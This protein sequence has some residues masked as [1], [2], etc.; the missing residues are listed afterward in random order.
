[1]EWD[2]SNQSMQNVLNI[3]DLIQEIIS[4]VD[5]PKA[6]LSCLRVN[7]EWNSIAK[8]YID[9]KKEQFKKELIYTRNNIMYHEFQFPNGWLDGKQLKHY[10]KDGKLITME[11][12]YKNNKKEGLC[13]YYDFYDNLIGTAYYSNDKAEGVSIMHPDNKH[14]NILK[15][16][17]GKIK[18]INKY[19]IDELIEKHKSRS[20]LVYAI[21][22]YNN[23]EIYDS[24][25]TLNGKTHGMY[26]D[27]LYYHGVKQDWYNSMTLAIILTII[28][29]L[30]IIFCIFHPSYIGAVYFLA[31][32][33]LA[34]FVVLIM[35]PLL[36]AIYSNY[37]D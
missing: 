37:F 19:K 7:K 22:R 28:V 25:E 6:F 10:K 26:N 18:V 16:N 36:V 34:Y 9:K 12:F 3:P 11:S 2:I 13:R 4:Q 27:D 24:E 8:L 17:N 1:M 14:T 31:Y 23:G 33:I 21:D 32:P 35:V 29:I 5:E 20:D 15:N 30:V